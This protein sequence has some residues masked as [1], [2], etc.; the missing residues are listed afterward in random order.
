MK[1]KTSFVRENWDN[2]KQET[3]SNSYN[4]CN[5]IAIHGIKMCLKKDYAMKKHIATALTPLFFSTISIAEKPQASTFKKL[6]KGISKTF[7]QSEPAND[8][9]PENNYTVTGNDFAKASNGDE[10]EGENKEADSVPIYDGMI[11]EGSLSALRVSKAFSQENSAL[12]AVVASDDQKLI[13]DL[14]IV[15]NEIM[16]LGYDRLMIVLSDKT[17][18]APLNVIS[19][20][21]GGKLAAYITQPEDM[22]GKGAGNKESL[23]ETILSQYKAYLV[24]Q[25]TASANL[26]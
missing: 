13:E 25:E 6:D 2:K 15:M 24:P 19:L 9:A 21:V 4:S 18:G 11:G 16:Q 3:R 26:D 5:L 8:A 12:V 23:K 17:D 20:Y 14:E 1:L 22:V 7:I 10:G